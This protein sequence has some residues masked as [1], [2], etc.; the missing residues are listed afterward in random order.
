[1]SKMFLAA[2]DG[3][4]VDSMLLVVARDGMGVGSSFLVAVRRTLLVALYEGEERSGRKLRE[5]R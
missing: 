2:R 5:E 1:M 4:G 3:M